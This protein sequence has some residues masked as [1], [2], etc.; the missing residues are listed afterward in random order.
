MPRHIIM[1]HVDINKLHVHIIMFHVDTHVN[2]GAEVC[3]LRF[4]I[5]VPL[6][7]AKTQHYI[8]SIDG[9]TNIDKQTPTHRKQWIYFV[10]AIK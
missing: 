1:L 8:S 6:I 3:G 7:F 10:C 5:L 4:R 9:K 2:N